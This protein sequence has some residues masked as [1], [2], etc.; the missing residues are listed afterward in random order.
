MN[1]GYTFTEIVDGRGE[2]RPLAAHLAS[3]YGHSSLDQWRERIEGGLVL[4]G[5]ARA[6]AE[7][8]L[9][10]GQQVTWTRPPWQEPE[11]PGI[12]AVLYEDESLL[13]VAK[14]SGL[15]TLPGGGYL[16]NTLLSLVRRRF[17]GASPAHRLGRGTS[18]IVLF[19][20][21]RAASRAVAEAWRARRVTKVYRALVEGCPSWD[22]LQVDEPIG[23]QP[24]PLLG[25]IYAAHPGGKAA[26][27]LVRVLQR[28]EGESLVEVEIETGRPHQIRIHTAACGHPLVGDPL[29]APGGALKAA[30]SPP[31]LPGDVGYL[32]HAWRLALPHPATRRPFE[33]ECRPPGRLRT[34]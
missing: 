5:G 28:R 9:K 8:I 23:L 25:A 6:T 7:L 16:E 22:A 10:R 27:S 30:P 29:Y 2:G 21:G 1:K 33:V 15:P 31:A 17:P 14:P 19:T 34:G 13:A 18:G 20:L 12:Y 11:V 32:L 4:V 26:R 24:H 3:R